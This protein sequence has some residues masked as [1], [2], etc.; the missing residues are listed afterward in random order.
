[1]RF[2][3]CLALLFTLLFNTCQGA[4]QAR[5][6]GGDDAV[7]GQFPYQASLS[8]GGS[9]NCGAVIIAE[10]Y[11]LTALGCVCSKGSDKPWPPQLFQVAAGTVDLYTGGQR[12]TVEEILVNPN[13]I[14]LEI[15]VALLRLREPMVFNEYVNAV[16]LARQNPPE[17]VTI[18]VSGWGRQ[19]DT[20]ENMYRTL[21]LNDETVLPVQDCRVVSDEGDLLP[22]NEQVL[23]L[24]HAR[25]NGICRGDFGGPAVYGQQLVG[26]AADTLGECGSMMP[27]RFISIA[28]NYE[29]IIENME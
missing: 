8:I 4:P 5:I 2:S 18:E 9:Y 27:D 13:Y 28:A 21:Q 23:C 16:P 11:A 24:G 17:G 12:I 7:L 19:K 26:L 1:M 3:A 20:D 22:L 6:V 10:R 15:G 29:W 14:E 25:K